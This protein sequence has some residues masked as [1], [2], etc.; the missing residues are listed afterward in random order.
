MRMVAHLTARGQQG[1]SLVQDLL[2]VER[3]ET[4]GDRMADRCAGP[5]A[6]DTL[7]GKILD[8]VVHEAVRKVANG[9]ACRNSRL[10]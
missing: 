10:P 9:L 6:C 8:R 1:R 4:E 7:V 5:P 2:Q 3:L